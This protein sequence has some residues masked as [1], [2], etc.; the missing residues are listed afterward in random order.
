MTEVSSIQ[1]RYTLTIPKSVREKIHIE[2][3]MEVFW[4]IRGGKIILT[5][6]TFKIFH[7][8][9]EGKPAYETERDKEEVEEAFMRE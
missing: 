3:G 1:R 2:E 7:E 9:F 6:K 4:S 8:R 5:P